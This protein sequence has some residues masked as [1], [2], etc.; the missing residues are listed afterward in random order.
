VTSP[1]PDKIGYVRHTVHI[2]EPRTTQQVLGELAALRDLVVVNVAE[3]MDSPA[4]ALSHD[5][6][7]AVLAQ[8]GDSLVVEALPF[9]MYQRIMRDKIE[10][11]IDEA[12]AMRGAL[13]TRVV[14]D[15][16]PE[17]DRLARHL[18]Q[19]HFLLGGYSLQRSNRDLPQAIQELET[20]RDQL[21]Q[22]ALE[23]QD[24]VRCMDDLHYEI[25]PALRKITAYF[26]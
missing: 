25:V 13:R 11:M 6:L 9:Q 26:A 3:S 7:S 2:V 20:L 17:A 23:Y 14:A 22:S 4:V 1:V 19:L 5:N 21:L 8:A 12:A 10:Q 18:E 24:N 16:G 15:L